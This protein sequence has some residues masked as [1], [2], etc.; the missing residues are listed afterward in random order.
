MRITDAQVHVWEVHREEPA[1]HTFPLATLENE[2]SAASV[3]RAVLIPT[4]FKGYDV[5]AA[6]EY[7]LQKC[8]AQPGKYSTIL[9]IDPKRPDEAD[10]VTQLAKRPGMKGFRLNRF[11][12][13][14]EDLDA[15]FAVAVNLDLP[16]AVL[17]N[18]GTIDTLPAM[19]ER[20]PGVTFLLDHVA[21]P[22]EGPDPWADFDKVLGVA[23]HKN[24]IVK[25]SSISRWSNDSYPFK[26]VQGYIHR[27]YDTFGPQRMAWGSDFSWIVGRQPYGEGLDLFR[28]AC[29]FLSESDKEWILDKTLSR[30]MKWD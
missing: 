4:S 29:D 8:A 20:H 7:T 21:L 24:L 10:R 19:L 11:A 5:D 16:V 17:V 3:Q 14:L 18:R 6:N 12:G 13:K 26:D 2:L 1:P 22:A 9:L 25:S 15:L 28:K 27:L 30:A 23:K